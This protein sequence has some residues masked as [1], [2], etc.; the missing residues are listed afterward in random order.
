MSTVFIHFTIF[1]ASASFH[2]GT[3]I[4]VLY[5]TRDLGKIFNHIDGI[6]VNEQSILIE[7]TKYD[8]KKYLAK[9]IQ[10]HGQTLM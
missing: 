4:Y 1:S 5:L 2:I 7:A 3:A 10:L 9:A 8:I 6:N